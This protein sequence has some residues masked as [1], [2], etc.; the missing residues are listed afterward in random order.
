MGSGEP[1]GTSSERQREENVSEAAGEVYAPPLL[2]V[3][4][5]APPGPTGG[6]RADRECRGQ[7]VPSRLA[8]ARGR[9]ERV[10]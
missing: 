5:G 6:T 2:N 9:M 1:H 7:G 4:S 3:I 10:V 8:G